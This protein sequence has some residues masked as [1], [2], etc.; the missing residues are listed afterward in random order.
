MHEEKI[1]LYRYGV[2]HR[3]VKLDKIPRLMSP[4]TA[5]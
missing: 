4:F 5:L 3:G 2:K 1:P